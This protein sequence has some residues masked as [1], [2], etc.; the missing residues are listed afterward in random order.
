MPF[1]AR[2]ALALAIA[3][4]AATVPI[5]ASLGAGISL[6]AVPA[7]L[8]AAPAVPWVTVLGL[9]AALLAPIL[10]P[11]AQAAAWA[12]APGGW[13]I[14]EIAHRASALPH[15]VLPWPGGW[16]GALAAGLVVTATLTAGRVLRRFGY[17]SARPLIAALAVAATA[18]VAIRPPGQWP[19]PD[20]VLV[21][22]D[23]GQGDALVIRG[24]DGALLVDTGP[25]PVHIDRCLSDLGVD[26]LAAIV[27]THAHADHVGGLAGALAGRPT[28]AVFVSPLRAPPEQADRVQA[29]A[30]DSGIDVTPVT[31][32]AAYQIDA[33]LRIDVLWPRAVTVRGLR[34]LLTGDVETA[35]QVA[36]TAG[37]APATAPAT[38]GAGGF[39]VAKVPH[40]GS[41]YFH[42]AFPAWVDPRIALVTVGRD[43]SY[44]HPSPEALAAWGAG[45]AVI[46]RTDTDGAL[47]VT[48]DSTGRLQLVRRGIRD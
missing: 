44:G 41:A 17:G 4:Q 10:P 6:A 43:N 18:L 39:D 14:A 47:A 16:P 26:R 12:A 20:W 42:P 8:L 21:A 19:P 15:A 27:L 32:G 45:G 23:V 48:L 13:W 1:A 40:H 35:A 37:G 24:T 7:N 46:G 36:I 9:L 2:A 25:D 29:I 5:I 34:L 3:A 22:C 11:L 33:D 28:G 30:L 31:A 38:A